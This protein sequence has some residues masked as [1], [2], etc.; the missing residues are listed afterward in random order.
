M[1][2]AQAE[3]VGQQFTI[4][5]GYNLMHVNGF[6]NSPMGPGSLEKARNLLL[7]ILARHLDVE[8]RQRTTIVFDSREADLPGQFT[9]HEMLV[10]FANESFRAK[11]FGHVAALS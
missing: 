10:E 8:S 9:A 3:F 11:I 7:G 2:F 5:D 6:V 1:F 4:I